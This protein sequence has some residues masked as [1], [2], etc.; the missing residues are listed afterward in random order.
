MY[1]IRSYY[2]IKPTKA[3]ILCDGLPVVPRRKETMEFLAN[4]GFLVLYPRYR[5]TWE[6]D[7][8]FLKR[9]IIEEIEIWIELLKSG[10]IQELFSGKTFSFDLDEIFLVGVSFGGSV[11]LEASVVSGIS[12]IVALSPVVDF[13]KFNTIYLV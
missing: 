2:E 5:G 11:A 6:S 12:K 1:A 9:P 3:M 7:G 8:K 10:K 13:S 4:Q